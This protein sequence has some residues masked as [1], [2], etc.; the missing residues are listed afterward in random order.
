MT[1]DAA[2]AALARG[3][4]VLV[5]GGGATGVGI[6]W[7]ASTRGLSV[8]L[9]EARDFG[10]GTSSRST[11]LIHGGVRYLAQGRLGLVR[12]ALA[13][14]ALLQRQAPTLVRPLRFVV[15]VQSWA[16]RLKFRVGLGTYDL[17][18]GRDAF[19]PSRWL[20][21]SSLADLVPGLRRGDF[22]GAVSYFDG[23][24]DDT[25]LLFA[26]LRAAEAAGARCVNHA[27]VTALLKDAHGTVVG[28]A[29]TDVARGAVHEIRARCVINA[30]GPAA[31]TIVALDVPG[32]P[33][34]LQLSRGSHLVVPARFL[35]GDSAVL[36]PRVDDGR[37]M[38]AIPWL[39]HTLLGTTDVAAAEWEAEPVPDAAEIDAILS[40]AAR[41]LDP[42]PTRADVTAMFCGLRP[43]AGGPAGV[44]ARVSREHALGVSAS[45][46]V[47]ITGGKWT[48]FRRMGTETVDFALAH[49]GL[50]AGPTRTAMLTLSP[51]P[52]P[53]DDTPLPGLDFGEAECRTAIRS[54]HALHIDDILAR[55]CR[56]LF[57][58][59]EA[60]LAAAPR[61][62][63]ILGEELALDAEAVAAELARFKML[64]ARYSLAR[65][66]PA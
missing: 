27:P 18:A 57:T 61:V 19:P 30:T 25:A 43:L 8:A 38:F 7:D 65:Q 55:R 13:E 56:A 28:A 15:P 16:E 66:R 59:V 22:A 45:G 51:P 11:K 40:T 23:Q 62:A 46:L 6:A 48:T 49:A 36:M 14:R 33:P 26:V 10:A 32:S 3:V 21:P 58:D 9:C 54:G 39:G 2:F 35:G 4:D 24:F 20:R 63:A 53:A 1:R 64:A 29:V 42:A 44:T 12:E 34:L 41:Y 50:V 31:G 5:I 37:V 60:A 52:R 47:T 17:L